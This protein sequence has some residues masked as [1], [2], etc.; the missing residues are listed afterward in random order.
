MGQRGSLPWVPLVDAL[1]GGF[2]E[3]QQMTRVHAIPAQALILVVETNSMSTPNTHE[4]AIAVGQ[5][6]T[7]FALQAAIRTSEHKH[8]VSKQ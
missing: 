2:P 4:P 7:G 3:S 6:L 5:H 8:A 1:F